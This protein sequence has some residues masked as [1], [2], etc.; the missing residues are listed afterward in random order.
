MN[1]SFCCFIFDVSYS[2]FTKISSRGK[3]EA[4]YLIC[5]FEIG[6]SRD[7]GKNIIVYNYTKL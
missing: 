5:Y 3:D 1:D 2:E 7:D 6:E 4:I